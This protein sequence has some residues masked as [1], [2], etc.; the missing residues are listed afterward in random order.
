M[1]ASLSYSKMQSFESSHMCYPD[2]TASYCQSN[3]VFGQVNA[4]LEGNRAEIKSFKVIDKTQ[5]II[6]FNFLSKLAL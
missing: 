6:G 2:S 5:G 3:E 4:R 1:I